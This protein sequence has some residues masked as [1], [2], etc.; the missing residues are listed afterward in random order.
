MSACPQCRKFASSVRMTRRLRGGWVKRS[1]TCRSCDN[2]WV[3]L[4]L[5]TNELTI[6]ET[7]REAMKELK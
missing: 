4:E 2:C 6:D 1:R 3:T 5:P 7:N